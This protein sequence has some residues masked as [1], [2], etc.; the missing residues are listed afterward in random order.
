MLAGDPTSRLGLAEVVLLHLY[1]VL[2]SGPVNYPEHVL[3]DGR[4]AKR[5]TK[6]MKD[7]LKARL[8]TGPQSLLLIGH[9]PKQ[10]TWPYPKSRAWKYTLS[11]T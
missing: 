6:N 5:A 11:P 1:L 8:R 10:V 2:L 3:G 7:P 9:W 4:G